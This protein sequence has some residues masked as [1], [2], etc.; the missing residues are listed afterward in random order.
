MKLTRVLAGAFV[1]LAALCATACAPMELA[2][3]EIADAIA[4]V[5]DADNMYVL[6][7]QDAHSVS[8]P[9][10]T[11]GFAFDSYFKNPQWQYFESDTGKDVVEFTGDCQHEGQKVKA[12]IQFIV[13]LPAQSCEPTHLTFNDVAQDGETLQALVDTALTGAEALVPVAAE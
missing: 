1:P 10:V 4:D 6:L 11:F 2:G 12:R 9:D 5:R 7:A 13:D 3:R 8:H